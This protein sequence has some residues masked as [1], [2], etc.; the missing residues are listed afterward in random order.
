MKLRTRFLFAEL[1]ADTL[2]GGKLFD[3]LA[4]GVF[5]DF[6]NRP[7]TIDAADFPAYITNTLAAIEATRGESGELGGLP[8]DA[9]GHG[10]GDG[11]GWIVG[12]QREG[13]RLR[14]LPKWTAFGLE[15]I[16]SGIRKFFSATVDTAQKIILGGTLTNWPA[17][18]DSQGKVMLRPIELSKPL[19]SS[20]RMLSLSPDASMDE[21]TSAVR[22]AWYDQFNPSQA[23]PT[24]PMDPAAPS[25]TGTD[26]PTV[27]EVFSDHIVIKEG[28]TLYSVNW[29]QD[30][31]GAI[32][33]DGRDAWTALQQTYV[34]A[35]MAFASRIL[36]LNNKGHKTAQP[37]KPTRLAPKSEAPVTVKLSDLSAADRAELAQLVALNLKASGAPAEPVAPLPPE[38]SSLIGIGGMSAEGKASLTTWMAAQA[39]TV[40]EQ[41]ELEFKANL[42]KIQRDNTLT[43]LSQRL[44]GGSA[45]HPRGLKGITAEQLKA[46]LLALPA[47]EAN[48]FGGLL[49]SVVE[50]GLLEF[51]ELGHGRP[52][53]GTIILAEPYATFLTEWVENKQTVAEFFEINAR[54]L[55]DMN[56]YNLSKYLGA[57]K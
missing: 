57:A 52:V 4:A 20:T 14:L 30:D 29:S 1:S 53:Q 44:T 31:T 15:L 21:I 40:H 23:D 16:Q 3:G 26:A 22:T 8:I 49:T 2:I 6:N 25:M 32:V 17:T 11:A 39:K 12:I 28:D 55:G 41:A 18:R 9:S 5:T 7:V 34:E 36:N 24:A 13:D 46:H 19:A 27:Q 51:T 48:Y 10:A 37:A 42:A 43:E 47:D 50:N 54:E 56:S 38:L 35:A 33:F 45:E